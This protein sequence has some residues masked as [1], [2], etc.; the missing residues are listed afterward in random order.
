MCLK[1]SK[2]RYT[3]KSFC[4]LVYTTMVKQPNEQCLIDEGNED[5]CLEEET[6]VH[7][8]VKRKFVG[9]MKRVYN[10][11]GRQAEARKE[12]CENQALTFILPPVFDYPAHT[13]HSK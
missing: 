4:L 6:G 3:H 12:E 8:S 11:D 5:E 2:H 13:V 1:V 7:L 10:D 9:S